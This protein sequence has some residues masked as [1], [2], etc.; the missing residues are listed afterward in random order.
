MRCLLHRLSSTVTLR[1][2]PQTL[3]LEDC[4]YKLGDFGLAA[5]VMPDEVLLDQ[6][7]SPSTSAPEVVRGRPYGKPADLWSAG[8]AIYTLLAGLILPSNGQGHEQGTTIAT[9]RAVT[10]RWTRRFWW[11]KQRRWGSDD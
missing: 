10:E 2:A 9:E 5:C 11:V 3:A 8:A 4:T 7:G 6:V 1:E